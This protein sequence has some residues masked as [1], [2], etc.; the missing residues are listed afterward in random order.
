MKSVVK[1]NVTANATNPNVALI[2]F[3]KEL[4]A[5]I[6][7][8]EARFGIQGPTITSQ[9]KSRTAKPRKG[10]DRVLA[11]LAPIVRQ[12]GLDSPSLSSTMMLERIDAA[13]TLRPLATRLQ[14]AVNRVDAELFNADADAWEMGL[15]FYSLLQ[16]RAKSDGA[17]AANLEPV[18][19]LFGYR[20]PSNKSGKLTKLQTRARS[21]L[22]RAVLQASKHGI[23]VAKIVTP[24]PA[25]TAPP[26]T[27]HAPAVTPPA[28]API[29]APAAAAPVATANGATNGAS[30]GVT[31]GASNGAANG[32]LLHG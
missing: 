17:L 28:P 27:Q 29:V 10:G 16:R 24:G 20:H 32:T 30:N 6:D 13:Q 25:E 3:V 21:K 18:A 31:N 1:K 9:D 23:D 4:T 2:N 7:E 5:S 12:Y 22:E 19:R 26:P 15:Q 11:T 14:A 8:I